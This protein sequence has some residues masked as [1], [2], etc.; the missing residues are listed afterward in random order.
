M[1]Q[2]S[3]NNIC[4]I[5]SNDDL[6]VVLDFGLQPI[7]HRLL[8]SESE[9]EYRHELVIHFCNECGLLQICDPID[10]EILYSDFNYCFS[11]WKAQPHA[12]DEV[13]NIRS[14]IGS[15]KPASAFEIGC[16]DG[17]FLDSLQ[18]GGFSTVVGLEPNP[19]AEAMAQEKG[20]RV[21]SGMLDDK[22]CQSAVEEFGRFDV[23]V[24]RQV[25]EHL[26]DIENYFEC[27]HKLLSDDGFLFTDIPDFDIALKARDCSM[28]WEEH[29]NYFTYEVFHSALLKFGF[30]P[31]SV[32]RYNF[33][34]GIIA[35]M[36][37]RISHVADLPALAPELSNQVSGWNDKVLDYGRLLENAISSHRDQ[38]YQIVL[39][40]AGS[41]ACGVVNGLGVGPLIDFAIDDQLERQNMLMPGS[42]LKILPPQI[43]KDST[44][45]VLCLLAV[46]QENEA[47]VKSKLAGIVDGDLKFASCLAPSDI[48]QE[49]RLIDSPTVRSE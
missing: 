48:R 21:F 18:R 24:S 34:G 6:T 9:E 46:N 42:K 1:T 44:K 38:G 23:V 43:L 3:K 26:P 29:V 20:F 39:Y 7:A 10:P 30:E 47:I 13:A 2:N 12:D 17:F 31:V 28:V 32:K 40:G 49:L 15:S 27:A 4:R 5:C 36:A 11:T 41:R 45:P 14:H 35:V 22:L 33:S 37:R 16:N 25:L 19:I 8:T